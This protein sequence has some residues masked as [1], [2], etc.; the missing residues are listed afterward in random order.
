MNT[1]NT[2]TLSDYGNKV[3]DLENAHSKLIAIIG[4]EIF[5]AENWDDL[6]YKSLLCFSEVNPWIANDTDSI[7]KG[8]TYVVSHF[9]GE[10]LSPQ[11]I[12]TEYKRYFLGLEKLPLLEA[13]IL[14]SSVKQHL[15]AISEL[16]K[17]YEKET[18]ILTLMKNGPR[19]HEDRIIFDFYNRCIE[20]KNAILEYF[21][22]G[23]KKRALVKAR[24]RLTVMNPFMDQFEKYKDYPYRF[25]SEFYSHYFNYQLIDE[26]EHRLIYYYIR[27]EKISIKNIYIKDKQQFYRIYFRRN[28]PKAIFEG[29]NVWLDHLPILE[30]RRPIFDELFTLFRGR[31]WMAFFALALPQVEGLFTEMVTLQ[32]LKN[33][34][35]LP[36][37]VN[38]IRSKYNRDEIY[39]DYYQYI[40]PKL[41]NKF[42]HTGM[43]EDFKL[44][45]YDLLT[46]LYHLIE[47]I[48]K[49]ET[50]AIQLDIILKQCRQDD[51]IS[52]KEFANFFN[53]LIQLSSEQVKLREGIIA[54]FE[55]SFIMTQTDVE[56]I[57][58][59]VIADLPMVMEQ[60]QSTLE[61]KFHDEQLLNKIY[62]E[63]SKGV[64]SWMV[65]EDFMLKFEEIKIRNIVE[66]D[67]LESYY[68]F[69]NGFSKHLPSLN[70]NLRQRLFEIKKEHET[71]ISN[72]LGISNIL[73]SKNIKT[74]NF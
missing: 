4:D 24:Y 61:A 51:F 10:G 26:V 62:N 63:K 12:K 22:Y 68:A 38:S 17:W 6:F 8:I 36:N 70:L 57:C 28:P 33:N 42:M 37:K 72:L 58:E 54:N 7:E 9:N 46:D 56:Y 74:A 59:D 32:G 2:I 14:E 41:R 16:I 43:E 39:F 53:L 29:I 44:K 69:L 50:P 64:K 67:E 19:K 49:W 5:E 25:A 65:D 40:L 27:S 21:L 30:R 52:Y 66:F 34:D 73:K 55:K 45:S 60:L 13:R 18:A 71:F 3:F 47:V 48:I 31:K 35:S 11:E 1:A 20:E 15:I 23:L